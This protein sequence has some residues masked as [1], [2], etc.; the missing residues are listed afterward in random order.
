MS[1]KADITPSVAVVEAVADREGVAPEDLQT[2]LYERLNPEA[3]DSL[4]RGSSGSVTFE[5]LEYVVTV[6]STG[7]VELEPIARTA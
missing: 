5:Y 7:T 2:P 4:F 1:K 6:D 3:L